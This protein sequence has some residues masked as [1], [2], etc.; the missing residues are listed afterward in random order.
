MLTDSAYQILTVGG[1][2]ND[3]T[4][5]AL[6]GVIGAPVPT[7]GS[8]ATPS[9]SGI[10]LAGYGSDGFIHA[11][12]TDING[13]LN[14][15]AIVTFPSSLPVTQATIPWVVQD[16]AAELSLADIEIDTGLIASTVLT[17]A[18]SP[19]I[20][21]LGVLDQA[22]GIPGTVAPTYATQIAGSD[23]TNLQAVRV[24]TNRTVVVI[25]ADEALASSINYFTADIGDTQVSIA[26]PA[27]KPVLSVRAN[28]AAIGFILREIML[29]GSGTN[30]RYQLIKNPTTLTGATFARSNGHMQIDTAATA[31]TG[32][33][34]VD[35][36][37]FSSSF[38]KSIMQAVASGA[39][40]DTFTLV[41][42]AISGTTKVAAA[43][44][45]S[46]T[47]AAL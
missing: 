4:G 45:W 41:A 5:D 8:P 47:A 19:P 43:V 2:Y 12:S 23:G 7:Q 28:S 25:P 46:E 39:P 40:G 1:L 22:D 42:S 44:Q 15:N 20:R 30:T 33:T 13:H 16:L 31:F 36:G 34:P 17:L 32:G 29:L 27:I 35:S 3:V 37:Y 11:L 38:G 6:F 21:V 9:G 18:G 14:V 26:N 24:S 10:I